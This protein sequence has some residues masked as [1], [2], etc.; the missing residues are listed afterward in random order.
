M[1]KMDLSSLG[2][3]GLYEVVVKT[4]SSGWD[5]VHAIDNFEVTWD[6]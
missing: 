3:T 1:Y 2:W 6:S 4:Q 5:T